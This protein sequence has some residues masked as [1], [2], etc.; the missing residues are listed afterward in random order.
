MRTLTPKSPNR[1]ALPKAVVKAQTLSHATAQPVQTRGLANVRDH[2]EYNSSELW[3][4]PAKPHL[5]PAEG[6]GSG[7]DHKPPDERTLKLGKSMY[8]TSQTL[9]VLLI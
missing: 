2:R 3:F 8:R 9:A 1:L 6:P 7:L 4:T 5:L